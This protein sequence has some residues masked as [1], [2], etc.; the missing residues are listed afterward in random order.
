MVVSHERLGSASGTAL[1]EKR[2]DDRYQDRGDDDLRG[3]D[4]PKAPARRFADQS[5]CGSTHD[6]DQDGHEAPD[7]LHARHQNAC[8]EADDD[9]G[10]KT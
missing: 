8:D 10:P 1:A 6:T 9:P 4:E 3:E 7:G 2:G 5:T